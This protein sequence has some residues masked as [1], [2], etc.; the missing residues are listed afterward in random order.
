MG[1]V[2]KSERANKITKILV[3]GG[4]P[5]TRVV[6]RRTESYAAVPVVH[7]PCTQRLAVLGSPHCKPSLINRLVI[8]WRGP[9]FV[10]AWRQ[11]S[12][13]KAQLAHPKKCGKWCE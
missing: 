4:E 10:R 3:Y 7:T 2:D 1:T 8:A 11:R 13:E 5:T 12:S 9:R 6:R